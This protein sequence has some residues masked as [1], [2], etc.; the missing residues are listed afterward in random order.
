MNTAITVDIVTHAQDP[1]LEAAPGGLST[2]EWLREEFAAPSEERRLR[3][4]TKFFDALL[5]EMHEDEDEKQDALQI[6]ERRA[7]ERLYG[8]LWS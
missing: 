7:R 8:R 5:A 2:W 4:V 6:P 3:A 1:V